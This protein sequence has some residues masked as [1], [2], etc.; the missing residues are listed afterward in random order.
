LE[1]WN[2]GKVKKGRQDKNKAKGERLKDKDAGS[3]PS[4]PKESEIHEGEKAGTIGQ[5]M[6]E[7]FD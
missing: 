4:F 1:E 7:S 5:G 2:S 6:K 3:F